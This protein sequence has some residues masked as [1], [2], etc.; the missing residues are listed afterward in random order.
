MRPLPKFCSG[1]LDAGLGGLYGD[2]GV[3]LCVTLCVGGGRERELTFLSCPSFYELLCI[4]CSL[5]R[6]KKTDC[7]CSEHSA[8]STGAN[9]PA[10]QKKRIS[11]KNIIA[12][13]YR[14]L[15]SLQRA[16]HYTPKTVNAVRQASYY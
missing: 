10:P 8:D 7:S 9:P 1:I 6:G 16:L 5:P 3:C 12:H 15:Y 2:G 13:V 11:P 4:L 14:A